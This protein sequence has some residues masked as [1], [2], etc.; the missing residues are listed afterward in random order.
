MPSGKFILSA[1]SRNQAPVALLRYLRSIEQHDCAA[2]LESLI[3]WTESR[4][5]HHVS[6]VQVCLLTVR[7]TIPVT[8]RCTDDRCTDDRY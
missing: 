4:Y 2:G 1:L 7:I 6:A 5:H 8:D 3:S